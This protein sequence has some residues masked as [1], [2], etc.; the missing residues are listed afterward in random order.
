MIV[1]QSNKNWLGDILNLY[2][3]WT[4]QKI[5]HSTVACML[6]TAVV[7]FMHDTRF[8][9]TCPAELN[10]TIFSLLGVVLSILLSFR[11]NTAY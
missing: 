3:S 8:Q 11:T 7:A 10:I 2:R 9:S 1:Y 4:M 6:Y 5:M